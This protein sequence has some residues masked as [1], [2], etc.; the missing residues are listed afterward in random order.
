MD[1]K[2]S[3]KSLS[4]RASKLKQNLQT[5]EATK[6]ALIMP[7]IQALGYD[8]FNP[9]EVVPELDCDLAKKKGEK[10]DYAIMKDGEAI[11]VIECKHWQQPLDNHKIQL[12][13]YFASSKA[14]FGL[15]TNGLEYRFYTDLVKENLMDEVPFLEFNIEAMKDV[16]IKALEKFTKENFDVNSI[17]S[18]ANELKFM[19]ELKKIIKDLIENP[20]TEFVKTL[21][22]QVYNGKIT[23]SVLNQFTELVKKASASYVNDK[24]SERLNIVV[25]TNEEEQNKVENTIVDVPGNKKESEIVTTQTEM[26]AYYIIKSI[27]REV[28][29]GNRVTMRDAISYCSIFIDD[30]N[31]KPVC[32]LHFN[33]ESNLRIE[34]VGADGKGDKIKIESLY[35]IFNYAEQLIEAAK[36][37]I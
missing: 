33:N 7:F 32:R 16:Q 21:A 18:S 14:K 15:L 10:I 20:N 22:K 23:E 26:E 17:M 19:S 13:R 3:L 11:L 6:N 4:E 31:R 5:E 2:E 9:L 25:K 30:N 12:A 37:Y 27:L 35:E 24:I 29:P 1:F 34:P 8:V 28:I 36:R